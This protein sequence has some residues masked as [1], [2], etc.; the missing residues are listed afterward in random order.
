VT[1][2]YVIERAVGKALIRV[3]IRSNYFVYVAPETWKGW[4]LKVR[5][6]IISRF[7]V[8]KCVV[9]IWGRCCYRQSPCRLGLG[10]DPV[11]R[12]FFLVIAGDIG[13][14]FEQ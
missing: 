10:S 7:F 4:D 8:I 9:G 5:L 3:A 12:C 6:D 13:A 1:S 2:S 11:H 14:L